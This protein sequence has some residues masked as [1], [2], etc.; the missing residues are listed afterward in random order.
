MGRLQFLELVAYD[1]MVRV[2][3]SKGLDPR[4]L[5]VGVEEQ[6][7]QAHQQ[8]PLSDEVIAQVLN[9]LQRNGKWSIFY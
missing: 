3:P 6:D 2:L 7:I 1:Q 5:V 4:L 8:W 9:N